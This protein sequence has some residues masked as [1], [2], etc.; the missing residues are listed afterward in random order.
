[1]RATSIEFS[2]SKPEKLL[3]TIEEVGEQLGCSRALIYSLIKRGDLKPI[4]LGRATRF[5]PADIA[6]LI[7][8]LA[9]R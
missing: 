8:M 4:K 6:N 2:A 9:A 7:D 3:L 5:R 1:M